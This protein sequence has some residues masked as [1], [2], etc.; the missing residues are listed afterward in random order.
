MIYKNSDHP[1][2]YIGAQFSGV[3][4]VFS[5]HPPEAVSLSTIADLSELVPLIR[6]SPFR[7]WNIDQRQ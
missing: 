1:C 6:C 4:S 7:V 5:F 2:V 3:E